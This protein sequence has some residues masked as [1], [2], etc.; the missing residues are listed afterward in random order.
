MIEIEV[1]IDSE[2]PAAEEV[3]SIEEQIL[4]LE[5][6]AEMQA[7]WRAQAEAQDEVERL[8]RTT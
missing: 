8:L 5:E 4:R 6:V 3:A 1:E 7:D 2:V